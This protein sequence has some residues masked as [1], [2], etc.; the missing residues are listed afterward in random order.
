MKSLSREVLAPNH[1]KR[2][3]FLRISFTDAVRLGFQRYTD[4]SGRST[5][6]EYWWWALFGLLVG[7][8]LGAVDTYTGTVGM[9]GNY[10][11]LGIL[12]QLSV[13]VPS[14]AVGARRL[15]DINMTGW[16]QLLHLVLVIG[17]IVIMVLAIKPGDGHENKYGPVPMS[18]TPE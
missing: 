16:W 17:S 1:G 3:W 8:I 9:F 4:F 12:F 10:G 5:R 2:R 13:L 18:P 11:L 14:L 15:H 6:A 7:I